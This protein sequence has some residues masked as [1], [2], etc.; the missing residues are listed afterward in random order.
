MCELLMA[1]VYPKH[2]PVQS[3]QLARAL[4]SPFFIEPLH[5]LRNIHSSSIEPYSWLLAGSIEF[6]EPLTILVH[7]NHK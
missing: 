6:R 3:Y 7:I 2:P 5:A 1:V 4:S